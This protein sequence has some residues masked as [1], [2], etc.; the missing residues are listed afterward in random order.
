VRWRSPSDADFDKVVITRA[1]AGAAALVVYSGRGERFA[2][3]SV[4]NGVRY[5]YEIR[6]FDR[7]GNGSGPVRLT[8]TPKALLLFSPRPNARVFSAPMLR[9]AAAR[10]ASYYNVQL[11]RGSKKVL[12]AWPRT[13]RLKLRLRWTF[14]GRREALVSGEYHWFVWP[15]RGLRSEANY[16][17]MLGQSSFVVVSRLVSQVEPHNASRSS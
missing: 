9:W 12:S 7:A 17:A 4:R 16:G 15:G 3:R 1:T 11:Y 5:T 14:R 6:A 8:A 13:N 10:G 2:D